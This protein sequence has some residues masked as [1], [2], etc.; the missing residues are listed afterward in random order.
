[1]ELLSTGL[2]TELSFLL[3]Q[4]REVRTWPSVSPFASLKLVALETG[5]WAWLC[6]HSWLCTWD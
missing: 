4:V 6:S 1:M 3:S 2:R 5:P